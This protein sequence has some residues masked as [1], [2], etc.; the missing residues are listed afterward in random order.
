MVPA[1]KMS[2]G[3]NCG[4]LAG[5]VSSCGNICFWQEKLF[6]W[7]KLGFGKKGG[8]CREKCFLTECVCWGKGV[9]GFSGKSFH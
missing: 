4:F 7:E 5:K 3:E 9:F 2:F 8:L 1:G 6:S